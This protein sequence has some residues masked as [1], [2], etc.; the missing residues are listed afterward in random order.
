MGSSVTK[1]APG[2]RVTGFAQSL[3]SGKSDNGA[4]QTYT[5]VAE[6]TTVKIPEK[7]NYEQAVL[8]TTGP[9]TAAV[10]LFDSLGLRLPTSKTSED[11]SSLLFVWGGSSAV[12]TM[13]IQLG[14]LLGFTVYATS[15]KANHD[16]LKS[17][18]ATEVFDYH[19]PTVIEDIISTAKKSTKS[20]LYGIDTISEPQTLKSIT[21]ILLKSGG[22]GAKLAHVLPLPD[23]HTTPD[24]LELSYLQALKVWGDRKD[25]ADWLFA[26]FLPSALADGTIIASPK[27][28]I[29]EGGITGL[30]AGMD[31]VKNGV[32]ATKIVV[33]L[34]E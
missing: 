9:A 16:Y 8:F 14:R 25:I 7:L 4:F 33:T 31:L 26:E 34:D 3:F 2:D 18:G 23:N 13:A 27:V 30:Q 6:T 5:A 11:Q 32:S 28:K 24:G 12:G 29:V 1:F 19:T 15:S 22:N 17:L 10:A 21:E 20:I